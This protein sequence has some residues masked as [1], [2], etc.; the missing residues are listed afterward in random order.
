V[1]ENCGQLFWLGVAKTVNRIVWADRGRKFSKAALYSAVTPLMC[2]TSQMSQYITASV[3]TTP[4]IHAIQDRSVL[5]VV[6]TWVALLLAV[7]GVFVLT[8]FLS[9]PPNNGQ[10]H[11]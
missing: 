2:V 11:S 5:N 3:L 6:V 4:L 10:G 8:W 7:L 1:T 9:N